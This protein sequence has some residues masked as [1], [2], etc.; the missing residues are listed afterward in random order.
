MLKTCV[1]VQETEKFWVPLGEE[2]QHYPFHYMNQH[3]GAQGI[4]DLDLT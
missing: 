1:P 2:D 4:N 3:Q